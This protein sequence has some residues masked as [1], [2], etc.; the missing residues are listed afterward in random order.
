MI[1]S[2]L[3]YLH[4]ERNFSDK[5]ILGYGKDLADLENYFKG[6]DKE[7]SWATIDTDIIRGWM[8][9]M[10][11]RGNVA[12]SVNRRLSSV[13]SFYKF[14]L[15][16]G[17]VERDPVRVIGS[18]RRNKRLPAFIKEREM[19]DLLDEAMWNMDK[20][21][22]VCTRTVILVFY[23]TGMRLSELV[24]LD[25]DDVDFVNRQIKVTGK[26]NKQRIIPFGEELEKELR[27]Y[28]KAR[29]EKVARTTAALFVTPKGER[30]SDASVRYRVEKNLSRV[31]TS[32]KRSPHVLRH[33]FATSMLNHGAGLESVQKLLGHE[34]VATTEIYTHTTFEKLKQ[35]YKAAHPR[36]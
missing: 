28:Q 26:R 33:T 35:I 19:Q 9:N 12:T 22:D 2:F 27:R 15:S 14:A 32:K 6:V 23:E 30:V 1:R 34:S 18:V 8:E 31:S 10:V 17:L 29:D 13:R 7:L 3:D 36:Q 16:R 20:F 5:T 4:Y 11:D 24:S 21:D 25:D